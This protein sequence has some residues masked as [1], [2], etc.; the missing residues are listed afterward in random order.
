MKK[1]L[2]IAVFLLPIAW[3][4]LAAPQI[5]PIPE[6][7]PC[8]DDASS[9]LTVTNKILPLPECYPCADDNSQTVAAAT[10]KILPLP[11]CYPCADDLSATIS[12]R[13]QS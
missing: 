7:W 4:K 2:L 5:L 10:T 12:R 1:T 13:R 9:T 8:A 6:C 11:E 3:A